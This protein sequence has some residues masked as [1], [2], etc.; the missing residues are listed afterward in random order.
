MPRLVVARDT[1]RLYADIWNLVAE[2]L[3]TEDAV[4]MFSTSKR[5]RSMFGLRTMLF[6]YMKAHHGNSPW[7]ICISPTWVES[8]DARNFLRRYPEAQGMIQEYICLNNDQVM[9]VD[10]LVPERFDELCEMLT[11]NPGLEYLI[12]SRVAMLNEATIT[13]LAKRLSRMRTLR[14][15]DVNGEEMGYDEPFP[16]NLHELI[17]GASAG[18]S[19][20]VLYGCGVGSEGGTSSRD[21]ANALR[22]NVGLTRLELWMSDV[23]EDGAAL[24]REALG[25]SEGEVHLVP[26]AVPSMP[27]QFNRTLMVLSLPEDTAEVIGIYAFLAER[28]RINRFAL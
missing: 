3:N 13:M 14:V 28:R 4:N 5:M 22:T 6:K 20:L 19:E 17:L 25:P 16:K 27:M 7:F 9:F 2:R 26:G 10:P 21:V 8:D 15:L 1:T 24:L 12:F 23:D 18:L 11:R